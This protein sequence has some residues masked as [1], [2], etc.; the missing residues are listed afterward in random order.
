MPDPIE[1]TVEAA[2]DAWDAGQADLAR[3]RLEQAVELAQEAGYL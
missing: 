2:I 1:P 3:E